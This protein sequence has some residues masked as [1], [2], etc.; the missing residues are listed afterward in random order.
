MVDAARY[1]KEFLGMV[2]KRG[3]A[4]SEAAFG[5]RNQG[6]GEAPVPF[7]TPFTF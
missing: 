1:V 4:P 6:V 2:Q 3:L 7:A 5:A